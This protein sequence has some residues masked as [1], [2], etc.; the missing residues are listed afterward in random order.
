MYTVTAVF[1]QGSR[2]DPP[3]TAYVEVPEP[4]PAEEPDPSPWD[5]AGLLV[6]PVARR[7]WYREA[8]FDLTRMS[9]STGGVD[10]LG[11]GTGRVVAMDRL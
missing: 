10:H 6:D 11:R 9:P 7:Q 5:Y 2:V 8:E 3:V 1:T 4:R